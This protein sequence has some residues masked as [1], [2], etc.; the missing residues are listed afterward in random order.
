MS[1]SRSRLGPTALLLPCA[2]SL[3][4]SAA[5]S[6]LPAQAAGTHRAA[7]PARKPNPPKSRPVSPVPG[8]RTL[9]SDDVIAIVEGQ[10]ITRRELT[11]YWLQVDKHGPSLLLTNLLLDRWKANK[12]ASPSYTFTDS[13]IYDRLYTNQDSMVADVLSSLVTNRLVA[14]E[15][16]RKGII[17][18]QTQAWAR[19]HELFDQFRKQRGLKQTDEELIAQLQLPRDIFLEDMAYRVRSEKL[20]AADIAERNGHPLQPDDWVLARQLHAE[21][22]PILNADEREKRF[23]EARR[24]IEGWVQEIKGGKSMEEVAR[25]HNDDETKESGGL[26]DLTL[27][28]TEASAIDTALFTLKPGELS[29]PI[30]AEGGWYVFQIERRG[31]AIPANER[32]QAW[33]EIV[34]ERLPAYLIALRKKA[35]ITSTIPLPPPEAPSST[36]PHIPTGNRPMLPPPPPGG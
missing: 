11:Y 36:A 29:A 28:G 6:I 34:E 21:V 9:R 24:V 31:A 14:I 33:K 15:A 35:H 27:R 4:L 17:V 1:C 7:P 32:D 23:A 30:R 26:R 3:I 22:P 12:G 10:P 16:K 20:L 13:E 25:D 8:R 19:A 5:L 2:L 18:T